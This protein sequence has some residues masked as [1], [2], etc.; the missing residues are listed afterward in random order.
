MRTLHTSL[1]VSLFAAL[2]YLCAPVL[3]QPEHPDSLI[4]TYCLGCHNQQD[5]AG[6]LALDAMDPLQVADDAPAWE[7]V[8][9]KLQAGMMP[10]AGE[11]RPAQEEVEQF[12]HALIHELDSQPLQLVASP[13]LHRLNRNEYRNAIRD[14]L[15]LDIDTS[16]LLPLDN[17]SEGFDNVA[18]GL[19]F[20]PALVQGYSSAAQKIARLALGD[21]STTEQAVS[22][23]FPQAALP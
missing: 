1:F 8:L 2:C 9:R 16:A 12:T 6:S 21:A 3:A 5:W 4:D 22:Y 23:P 13:A 20:S 19:G 17:A 7:K 18:S 10:P 14:L 15:A 11:P